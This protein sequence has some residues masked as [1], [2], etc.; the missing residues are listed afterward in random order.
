MTEALTT[1]APPTSM[2]ASVLVAPKT[3]EVQDIPVPVLEDD[4]VLVEIM[5]VG[6]CGS[7]THFFLHGH[8]GDLVVD[9]PLVLGHESAG[10]IVAVGSEVDPA[11]IGERVSIEPQKP[12][13]VCVYC[14]EGQYNLCDNMEF[15]GAPPIHGA[16]SEYAVIQ[17]DFAHA[18]PDH[19]SDAAAA[20][21]EPLSVAVWA[22][23]KAGVS[24]GDRIL[25]TGAGPIGVVTA[26]VA[27]AFGALEIIVS[28]PVE[29]RRA[30]V[31]RHGAT[32][33][34]DPMTEDVKALA[35]VDI[36]L[37]AS[38]SAP[39]IKSGIHAVRKGGRVVLV[40]MGLDNLELPVSVIQNREIELT[41]IYRYANT[42]PLAIKLAASGAIDLDSLV[43]GKLGLDSVEEALLK[44]GSDPT[45]LKTLV[46]PGLRNDDAG[47]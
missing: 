12:C 40:G 38:G 1:V 35:P 9:G 8:I 47:N 45:A 4:Q 24:P 46:I 16:F 20:L 13:R 27:R 21:I 15:Y 2:R 14:K 6:V 22:C 18:V 41:G 29:Q 26:Q 32:Q 25:I 31:A 42:W 10:R 5:A 43:T 19:L 34:I 7:D 37:D 36:F 44:A 33:T 11:R 39:A 28:D 17:S 3:V 30:V 23:Q